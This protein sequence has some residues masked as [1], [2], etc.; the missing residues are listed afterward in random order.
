MR[1]ESFAQMAGAV[2]L[3]IDLSKFLRGSNYQGRLGFEIHI[4]RGGLR[5]GQDIRLCRLNSDEKVKTIGV[6]TII[7]F[8]DPREIRI[9]CTKPRTFAVP[10][11][12][13]DGWTIRGE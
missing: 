12:N 5:V 13:L 4:V 10:E 6:E 3:C 1:G 2:V 8:D 9:H 11:G 7:D